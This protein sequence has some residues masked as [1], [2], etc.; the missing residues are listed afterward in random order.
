VADSKDSRATVNLAHRLQEP[1]P[2]KAEAQ[3]K[4][5]NPR[6]ISRHLQVQAPA[7]GEA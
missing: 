7:K 4:Q 1:V 2:V 3:K 6:L 5:A